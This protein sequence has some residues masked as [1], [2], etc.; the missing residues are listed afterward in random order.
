LI[1]LLSTAAWFLRDAQQVARG[2]GPAEGSLI[3]NVNTATEAQ[4]RTIP[5]V[6]PTRAAQIAASRPYDSMDDPN[7][8][9]GIAGKTLE[10]IRPVVTVEGETRKRE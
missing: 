9:A 8:I 1:G 6:G 3:V 10:S 5:G 7:R 4:L 2:F